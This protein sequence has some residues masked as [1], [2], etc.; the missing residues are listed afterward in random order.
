MLHGQRIGD[1]AYGDRYAAVYDE[2][3]ANRD[4]VCR[5]STVLHD[6]A[7][8]GDV[9]EFGVGT[10][11][12]AIPLAQRGHRVYGVDNSQAMLDVLKAKPGSERVTPIL[13]DFATVTVGRPVSLVFA[14]FSTIYLPGTQDAQVQTFQ[15]AAAHLAP[16]GKF[17][18]EAFVHDRT[19]FVNNQEI[20]ATRV[21]DSLATLQ[22]GVLDPAAQII[23]TQRMTFTKEGTTFLPNRLRF[24]YPAEMDLMARLAG[25]A[26]VERWS[27]WERRP[28]LAASENQIAVYAK[29]SD[30]AP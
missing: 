11:R 28:F 1:N 9:V 3:F 25:L 15:N 27:D 26:L 20:V 22:I 8:D 10:G 19:R 16:G 12:L 21:G 13:G 4:D 23:I 7:G 24:I 5:V 30:G 18:V 17:L 6:L 14:A 29:V 2:L